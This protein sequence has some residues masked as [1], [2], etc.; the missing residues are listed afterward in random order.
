MLLCYNNN[1]KCEASKVC[2]VYVQ[3]HQATFSFYP[4]DKEFLARSFFIVSCHHRIIYCECDHRTGADFLVSVDITHA[5]YG[6]LLSTEV[7]S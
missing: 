2:F 3:H 1:C 7:N 4:R 6:P 5:I